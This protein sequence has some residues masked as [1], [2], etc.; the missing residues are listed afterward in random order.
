V[1]ARSDAWGWEHA[2]KPAREPRPLGIQRLG[3]RELPG[4]VAG[5]ATVNV[6]CSEEVGFARCQ[7]IVA[8]DKSSREGRPERGLR[9]DR[10]QD[11]KL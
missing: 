7:L 6:N 1:A 11:P 8:P 2:C 5:P 10:P 3:K 4:T 9:T